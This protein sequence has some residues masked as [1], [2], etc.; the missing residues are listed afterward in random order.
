MFQIIT[1]TII[2]PRSW[3]THDES[4]V[5]LGAP[6][7]HVA[8]ASCLLTVYCS[9]CCDQQLTQAI[10]AVVFTF[11]LASAAGFTGLAKPAVVCNKVGRVI[12]GHM[13]CWICGRGPSVATVL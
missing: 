1:G 4:L 3:P 12:I 2:L 13:Q 7:Q 6:L 11:A 5:S 9:T 8:A 10:K